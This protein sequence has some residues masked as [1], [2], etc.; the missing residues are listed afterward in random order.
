MMNRNLFPYYKTYI[1]LMASGPALFFL[2]V[3]GAIVL[4]QTGASNV[5]VEVYRERAFDVIFVIMFLYTGIL[6]VLFRGNLMRFRCPHCGERSV[7]VEY[8]P[9]TLVIVSPR[10]QTQNMVARCRNCGFRQQTDLQLKSN[11]F[12]R[13]FPVKVKSDQGE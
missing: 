13:Q 8:D 7:Y 4:Y 11:M 3:G 9:S 12:I 10:V 5:P 6:V 1:C 2:L